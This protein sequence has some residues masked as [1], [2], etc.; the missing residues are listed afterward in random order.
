MYGE[1]PRYERPLYFSILKGIGVGAFALILKGLVSL[2]SWRTYAVGSMFGD[3]ENF[4]VYIVIF[5]ASLLV[6]NSVFGISMTYDVFARDTVM[7]ATEETHTEMPTL[8]GIYGYR[9]FWTET[10]TVCAFMFI[11]GLLGAFPELFGMFYLGEGY[12]PYKS[13]ILPALVILAITL[14]TCLIARYEAVK[15]W[16]HLL[17]TQSLN[18]V[19]SKTKLILRVITILILY[20]LVLPYLPLIFFAALVI[21]SVIEA[22]AV[23]MTVPV[24]ILTIILIIIGLRILSLL[25]A[26]RARHKF[27]NKVKLAAEKKDFVIR[28]IKNPSRSILSGRYKCTFS[29]CREDEKY[30]CLVIGNPK[31]RVPVC[32]TSATRGHYRHRIGTPKRNITLETKFDYSFEGEGKKLL[33]I[34][35]TPKHAFICEDGK[36]KR[37]FTADKLWDSVVYEA[38]GFIGSIE[39]DC[40][41]RHS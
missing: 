33:I 1:E 12:S 22:A 34:S 23:A 24:F 35:P 7:M 38:E 31:Y 25:R 26:I 5:I 8:R 10:A 16:K 9:D 40:L 13:G 2:F 14:I 6:Y 27:F 19:E 3:F 37:L 39:R 28:N 32:F 20:P 17:R 11:A 21:W 15:Y 30:D 18:A 41:G 36:E 4:A 29:L